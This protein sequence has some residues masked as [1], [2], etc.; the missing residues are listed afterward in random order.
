MTEYQ[1]APA[2]PGADIDPAVLRI[3]RENPKLFRKLAKLARKQRALQPTRTENGVARRAR[4][5]LSATIHGQ[6]VSGKR[7]RK[8][9]KAIKR[10]M[11]T[12][13]QDAA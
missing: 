3:K 5:A 12:L 4:L 13:Q 2:S 1:L 9:E 8:D 10:A 6:R 7:A 11:R